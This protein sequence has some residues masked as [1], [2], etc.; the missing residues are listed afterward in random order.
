MK[1]KVPYLPEVEFDPVALALLLA[2]AIIP[3]GVNQY[4][5]VLRGEVA[6]RTD[7]VADTLIVYGYHVIWTDKTPDQPIEYKA[8]LDEFIHD[9][10]VFRP[11]NV[12]AH[13]GEYCSYFWFRSSGKSIVYKIGWEI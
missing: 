13:K 2:V 3:L 8:T 10:T 1:V 4:L 7:E 9:L 12:Y 5:N 11:A 6:E